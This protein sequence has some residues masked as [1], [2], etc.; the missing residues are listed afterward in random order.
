MRRWTNTTTIKYSNAVVNANK[1]F[2][3]MMKAILEE[4]K[5]TF[6]PKAN[7]AKLIQ[8]LFEEEVIPPNLEF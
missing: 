5:I 4:L 1:A 8:V 6:D 2:E 3:S 7:A